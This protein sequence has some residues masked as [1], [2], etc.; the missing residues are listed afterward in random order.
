[1]PTQWRRKPYKNIH[2]HKLWR[3]CN[4][5]WGWLTIWEFIPQLTERSEPLRQLLCKDTTWM[6][7]DS[8]QRAFEQIK[9]TLTSADVK[10]QVDPLSSQLIPPSTALAES[11]FRYKMTEIVDTSA[12]HYDH[13]LMP[14]NAML[15]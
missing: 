7:S 10:T 5:S 15:L 14:K 3:I 11:Y 12:M 2:L 4:A 6:W 13:S 1:M 8:H 9:T